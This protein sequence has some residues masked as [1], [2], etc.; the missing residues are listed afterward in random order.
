MATATRNR[1]TQA[2]TATTQAPPAHPNQP[3]QPAAQ[4][5]ATRGAPFSFYLISALIA[6]AALIFAINELSPKSNKVDND[7]TTTSGSGGSTL[8]DR[9]WELHK[10]RS[11]GDEVTIPIEYGYH[12]HTFGEKGK[13]YGLKPEGGER[14]VIG[15]GVGY[16]PYPTY[17]RYVY[18][19]YVN[20]EIDVDCLTVKNGKCIYDTY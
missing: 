14:Q 15:N 20:E 5:R 19:S 9:T 17:V 12:L 16:D 3:A 4:A 10:L 13:Q 6:V 8:R 11:P 2:N 1:T 7:G 18:I